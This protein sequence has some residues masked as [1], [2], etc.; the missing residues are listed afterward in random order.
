MINMCVFFVR[1][2]SKWGI[3]CLYKIH[4]AEEFKVRVLE[5]DLFHFDVNIFSAFGIYCS[6]MIV[7]GS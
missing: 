4:L 1:I 6:R 5:F 7:I 2:G 3:F